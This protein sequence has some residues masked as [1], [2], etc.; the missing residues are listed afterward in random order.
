MGVRIVTNIN[1]WSAFIS[2]VNCTFARSQFK[3]NTHS[4]LKS[5]ITIDLYKSKQCYIRFFLGKKW[6]YFIGKYFTV[7]PA[8]YYLMEN[9]SI[10]MIDKRY[11][12]LIQAK[13][14]YYYLYL[15]FKAKL[16]NITKSRSFYPKLYLFSIFGHLKWISSTASAQ[17][18]LK[19]R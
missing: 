4:H 16:I 3:K 12:V 18:C 13:S 19:I 6:Y 14:N 7:R 8:S 10:Q 5:S 2:R 1:V 15:I 11:W 17:F 9:L